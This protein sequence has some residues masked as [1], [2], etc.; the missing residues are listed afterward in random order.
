L[1]DRRYNFI[2]WALDSEVA[3][4]VSAFAAHCIRRRVRSSDKESTMA[5]LSGALP[6]PDQAPRAIDSDVAAELRAINACFGPVGEPGQCIELRE[7]FTIG[8]WSADV[9][10][11]YPLKGPAGTTLALCGRDFFVC[12]LARERDGVWRGRFPALHAPPGDA[13]KI[14]TADW[15]R[16]RPLVR[17][18]RQARRAAQALLRR[19]SLERLAGR[20]VELRLD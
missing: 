8:G 6:L 18:M 9:A 1:L 17:L 14:A 4:E 5:F 11:W 13:P 7:D 20:A 12:E 16:P 3:R 15:T 2:G 19:P 10:F